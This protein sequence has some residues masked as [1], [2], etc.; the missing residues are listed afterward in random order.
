MTHN[1]LVSLVLRSML[2]NTNGAYAMLGQ[3]AD[4]SGMGSTRSE[5]HYRYH[6]VEKAISYPMRPMAQQEPP[7]QPGIRDIQPG[8]KSDRLGD[9][10][11]RTFF[12]EGTV[13]PE[14]GFSPPK[15]FT[16]SGRLKNQT[17]LPGTAW[18]TWQIERSVMLGKSENNQ[19][20]LL[21]AQG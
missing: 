18:E 15:S 20:T 11:G 4:C 6:F 14:T 2:P 1:N 7:G 12:Q 17:G 13:A 19:S 10:A 3:G 21:L 9:K 8:M 16:S 5:R